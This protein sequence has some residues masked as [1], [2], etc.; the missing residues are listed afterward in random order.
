MRRKSGI[1]PAEIKV[2]DIKFSEIKIEG[3]KA[4]VVVDVFS[5]RHCFNLEKENGEWKITSET[6]NFLPGY[7]P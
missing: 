5:E 2:T 1:R 7:G 6:L 4:T 3:D